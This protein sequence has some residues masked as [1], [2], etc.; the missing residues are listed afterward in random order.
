MTDCLFYPSPNRVFVPRFDSLSAVVKSG[1]VLDGQTLARIWAGEI[2][3]WDNEAIKS[4]NPTV[5]TK[6]PVT[7]ILLSFAPN[8][9]SEPLHLAR[10]F[11][12]FSFSWLPCLVRGHVCL[13]R[14]GLAAV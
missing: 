14:G 9:V 7:D 4:L 11:V 12:F 8:N 2:K 6:L 10:S 13:D 1:Q 3:T 5:A